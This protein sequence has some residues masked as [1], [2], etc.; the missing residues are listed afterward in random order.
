MLH[1]HVRSYDYLLG[2]QFLNKTDCRQ[3][4]KLCLKK[5]SL[6]H[7]IPSIGGAAKNMAIDGIS[8]LCA[9]EGPAWNDCMDSSIRT[10]R[11]RTHALKTVY[12]NKKTSTNDSPMWRSGALL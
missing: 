4:F 5:A 1:L 6:P 8:W 11:N 9:V 7:E 10:L 3:E 12:I 2:V